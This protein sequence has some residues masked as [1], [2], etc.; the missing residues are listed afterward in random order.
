MEYSSTRATWRV[1]TPSSRAGHWSLTARAGRLWQ[2]R[3]AFSCLAVLTAVK[4]V[5]AMSV[6]QF[7]ADIFMFTKVR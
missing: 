6:D 5:R 1:T 7:L 3:N 2:E 4:A